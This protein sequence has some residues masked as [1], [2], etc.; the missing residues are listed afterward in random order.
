MQC[1]NIILNTGDYGNAVF[2]FVSITAN[3]HLAHNN[4]PV[5]QHLVADGATAGNGDQFKQTPQ[6]EHSWKST[7]TD[8]LRDHFDDK[9]H[10]G[11]LL[12]FR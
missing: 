11:D 10:T 5:V 8:S 3:K 12:W 6:H 1:K 4:P 7:S 9:R 2:C